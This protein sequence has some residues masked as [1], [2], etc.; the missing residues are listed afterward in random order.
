MT[1]LKNAMREI[2]RSSIAVREDA[3]MLLSTAGVTGMR[4][5]DEEGGERGT[6]A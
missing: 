6:L 3:N 5:L 4:P 1:H 2:E